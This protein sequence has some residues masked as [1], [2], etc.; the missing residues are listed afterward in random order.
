MGEKRGKG[1]IV[2]LFEL[3]AS[4]EIGCGN[5][6]ITEPRWSRSFSLQPS[7]N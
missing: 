1:V 7:L 6:I 3:Y 2:V 4:R 5:N